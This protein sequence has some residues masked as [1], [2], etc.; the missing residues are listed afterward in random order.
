MAEVRQEDLD[1]VL[2]ILDNFGKSETSRLKIEISKEQSEGTA[3]RQYHLGRCDVGSPW[4]KGTACDV[5]ED[6]TE[7]ED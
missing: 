1:N 2:K 6:V 7:A 3:K 4:A 5:I